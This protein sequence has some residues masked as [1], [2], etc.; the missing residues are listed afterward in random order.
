MSLPIL[1]DY[2]SNVYA[3]LSDFAVG[4]LFWANFEAV[5]G[6]EYDFAKAEAM[7]S[8]WSMGDFSELPSIEVVSA[9]V[10]SS[11]LGGYAASNNTIY[12]SEALLAS[13]SFKQIVAVMLEEIGHF[14][15]TAVIVIS[16][17]GETLGN[18][19]RP[20]NLI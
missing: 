9:E 14:V 18:A 3:Y 20:N 12:L 1:A 5:Y 7:R 17:K 4:E 10:L 13:D 2:L 15:D 8:R 6:T 19:I 11:A 16:T